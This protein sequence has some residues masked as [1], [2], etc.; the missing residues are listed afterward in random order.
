MHELP[1]PSVL[2]ETQIRHLV[3]ALQHNG[4]S[5]A[6]DDDDY[7]TMTVAIVTVRKL[8]DVDCVRRQPGDDNFRSVPTA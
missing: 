6:L 2:I 5:V 1:Q 7:H 8:C 3:L 4:D